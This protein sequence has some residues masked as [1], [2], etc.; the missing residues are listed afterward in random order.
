M[1]PLVIISGYAIVWLLTARAI[2]PRID[3]DL[4]A[5]DNGDRFM[6]AGL[7][8]LAAV[9]WPLAGPIYLVLATRR[10]SPRELKQEIAER[11]Q[12][13]AELESELGIG[14]NA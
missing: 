12:R 8:C 14:R 10:K 5:K 9:F 7:A 6:N 2:L 4:G 11:N 13:I 3:D 1:I